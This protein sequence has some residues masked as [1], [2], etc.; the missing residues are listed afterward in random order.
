MRRFLSATL[1]VFLLSWTFIAAVPAQA[2]DLLPEDLAEL[3]RNNPRMTEEDAASLLHGQLPEVAPPPS[4]EGA[5]QSAFEALLLGRNEDAPLHVLL[6]NFFVL[7]VQHILE[8]LDHVLFVLSLLLA[9]VSLRHTAKLITAFTVAHTTTFLVAGF[10]WL[11]LSPRIVEPLIALSI[12]Y[13]AVTSMFFAKHPWLGGAKN[14]VS[15]VFFFGLFHGLGFAGLL[16][17]FSIPRQN[18]LPALLSFNIGI[19]FG[20]AVILA[21]AVPYILLL[22]HKQWFAVA[23][24]VAAVVLTQVALIWMCERLLDVKFLPF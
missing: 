12:A 13:M 7:G 10:G 11:T 23:Q 20:Q 6:W 1:T 8:G 18:F 3:M 19:E 24:K 2:H 15:T 16:S 5:Q 4:L 22:R 17:D 9:F 14:K 21:L